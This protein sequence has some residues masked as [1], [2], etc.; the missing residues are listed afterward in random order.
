MYRLMR[1]RAEGWQGRPTLTRKVTIHLKRVTKTVQAK[2][3]LSPTRL[4]QPFL[5]E[6]VETFSFAGLLLPLVNICSQS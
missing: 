6:Q 1:R 2:V 5:A 3:R 4:G